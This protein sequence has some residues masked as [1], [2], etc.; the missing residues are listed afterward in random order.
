MNVQEAFFYSKGGSTYKLE[1]NGDI[2]RQTADNESQRITQYIYVDENTAERS[3]RG[4]TLA[5][6]KGER[7]RETIKSDL[8]KR[9]IAHN[10]E[11]GIFIYRSGDRIEW[12]T[13]I[14]KYTPIQQNRPPL[15]TPDGNNADFTLGEGVEL[16]N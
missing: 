5:G 11:G 4:C 16:E 1:G 3:Y 6:D 15:V 12:S 10:G 14:N 9:L 8:Q 7:N 2:I 13:R